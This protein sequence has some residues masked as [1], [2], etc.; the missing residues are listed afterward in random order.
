MHQIL[1][2]LRSKHQVEVLPEPFSTERVQS[3]MKRTDVLYVEWLEKYLVTA[4]HLP[5]TCRIVVRGHASDLTMA[6]AKQ[7]DWSKVDLLI[8]T[9]KFMQEKFNKWN[10]NPKVKQQIIKLGV[11][12]TTFSLKPFIYNRTIGFCECIRPGKDILPVITLM[13]SLP[14]WTLNLRA[15]P[16]LFPKLTL[17]VEKLVHENS[18]VTWLKEWIPHEKM[19]SFYQNLDILINNSIAEGQGVAILEAMACG[20]YPLIHN[21]THA[22]D[23][24]PKENIYATLQNCKNK[25]LSWNAKS[26]GEKRKLTLKTRNFIDENYNGARYVKEIREALEP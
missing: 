25:I 20:V 14:K 17:K 22:T 9:N 11:D 1:N 19:P 24:Y 16:G 21:W 7:A 10:N 26:D 3:L 6:Y 18:N 23:L 12:L 15:T 5:K 4:T 2:E 13:K 8:F